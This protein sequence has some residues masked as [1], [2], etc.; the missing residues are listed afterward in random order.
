MAERPET[1]QDIHIIVPQDA[2]KADELLAALNKAIVKL[3]G[4]ARY[5]QIIAKHI[6]SIYPGVAAK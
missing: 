1:F 5:S 3:K 2:P 6:S 4:D